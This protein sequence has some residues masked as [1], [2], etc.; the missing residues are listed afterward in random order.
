MLNCPDLDSNKHTGTEH[1]GSNGKAIGVGHIRKILE[2]RNDYNC[3]NHKSPI[4][5]R[6]VN[7]TLDCLRGMQHANRWK[8][9]AMDDLLD[10]TEGGRDQCL[11]CDEL[12]YDPSEKSKFEREDY[13]TVAR[14]AKTNTILNISE[15]RDRTPIKK[16]ELTSIVVHLQVLV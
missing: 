6:Y 9:S 13:I 15:V 11:W 8:C 10:K 4:E 3:H 12:V 1:D 14:I 7:L 2:G 16:I 5:S